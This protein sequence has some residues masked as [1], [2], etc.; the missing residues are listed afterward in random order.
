M[1]VAAGE[2]AWPNASG[3]PAEAARA[4]A[5]SHGK[6]P[7]DVSVMPKNRRA[8]IASRACTDAASVSPGD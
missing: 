4:T 1:V 5:A 8:A 7:A 3:L 6:L 2:F